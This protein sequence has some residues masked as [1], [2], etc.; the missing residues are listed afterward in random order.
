MENM[1]STIHPEP[2]DYIQDRGLEEQ[3]ITALE[4]SCRPTLPTEAEIEA[5]FDLASGDFVP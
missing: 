5:L 3:D 1:T 4:I 2:L